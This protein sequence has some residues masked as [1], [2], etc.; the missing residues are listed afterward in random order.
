MFEL[1][2][3]EKEYRASVEM[4]FMQIDYDNQLVSIVSSSADVSLC[5]YMSLNMNIRVDSRFFR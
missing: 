2:M 5:L 1:E 3:E 4:Q